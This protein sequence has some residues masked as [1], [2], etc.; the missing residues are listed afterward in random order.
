MGH[1]N[2]GDTIML[3]QSM[4]L[5]YGFDCLFFRKMLENLEAEDIIKT[6]G[7][8]RSEVISKR[9]RIPG[10]QFVSRL[11][12]EAG[13]RFKN[14][15]FDIGHADHLPHKFAIPCAIVQNAQPITR[16]G[17]SQHAKRICEAASLQPALDGVAVAYCYVRV[18]HGS[19]ESSL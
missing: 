14:Q 9:H 11:G 15:R 12:H 10:R 13:S 2:H 1:T 18:F 17:I 7:L 19:N 8:D 4:D 6:S 16:Q 3:Q 5:D